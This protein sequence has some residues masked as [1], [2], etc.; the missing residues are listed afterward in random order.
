MAKELKLPK[1]MVK[2]KLRKPPNIKFDYETQR[3][4]ND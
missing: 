3:V 2:I 4:K 1:E